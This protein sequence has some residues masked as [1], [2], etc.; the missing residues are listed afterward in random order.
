MCNLYNV[1]LNI[2]LT[3]NIYLCYRSSWETRETCT[4]AKTMKTI[5]GKSVNNAKGKETVNVSIR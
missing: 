2:L 3:V 1:S 4:E 5:V